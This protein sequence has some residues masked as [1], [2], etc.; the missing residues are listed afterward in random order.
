MPRLPSIRHLQRPSVVEKMEEVPS[1]VI[2]NPILEENIQ[3]LSEYG[4][5]CRFNGLWL[6]TEDLYSWIHSSWTK[7]CKVFLCSRGFFIVVF[8]D[9]KDYETALTGGPWFWGS[10]GLF[11][12]PWFPDFDRATAVITKLPI[13]VRL[14]NLPAHLWHCEVFEAIWNTL[15]HFLATEPSRGLKGLYT[16]GRIC[17]EIDI[18]KGLPD[19]IILKFGDFSWSQ[20]LDYENT[21]FHYRYYHKT[22]HLQNSC[23]IFFAQQKN[24]TRK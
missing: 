9:S 8:A 17:A 2:S 19:Q 5:I 12:T 4:L 10:A 1:V 14:P 15:G 22:G 13:W 6:R 7:Q 11:L 20:T 23:A 24:S 16:Y 18:S 3:F 21:T